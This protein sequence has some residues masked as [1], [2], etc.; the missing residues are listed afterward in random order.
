MHCRNVMESLLTKWFEDPT[1]VGVTIL[2]MMAILAFIMEWVVPGKRYFRIVSERDR[3]LDM[4]IRSNELL[5]R[6]TVSGV[7]IVK[8]VQQH[9]SL[10]TDDI[11]AVVRE[12]LKRN[13]KA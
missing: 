4:L 5:G 6:A 7:E 1:K 13:M 11:A 2:L 12:E 10:T 3:Y 9:I 8:N